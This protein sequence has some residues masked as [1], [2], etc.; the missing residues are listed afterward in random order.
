MSKKDNHIDQYIAKS[1][2]YAKPILMH[3][4]DLVHKACPDVEET[5]KWGM[6]SFDYK[7]PY[8]GMAA[9]KKHAVFGFWKASL[10]KDPVLMDN[11]KSE[12]AMGHSGQLT[13][14]KDLPSDKKMIGYLKEAK[15]LNDDGVKLP[16]RKKTVKKDI[17]VP[18]YMMKAIKENTKALAVFDA[19]SPS[20]KNEYIEWVTE[21][22]TD[23]TREKR[24]ATMIEWLVEG[25]S[26]NWKY[27]RK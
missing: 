7:G 9:F 3:L 26:R 27:M 24:T 21:A 1:S 11:A 22:K 18:D 5:I 17:V 2:E 15:K 20:H 19:F 13:S 25:K 4:R 23:A 8:F 16:P 12:R 14:M 10:M 6:P